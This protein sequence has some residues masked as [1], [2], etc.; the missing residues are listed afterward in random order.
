MNRKPWQRMALSLFGIL[1]IVFMWRWTVCHLY[2]L[3]E[4][5]LAPFST[6]TTNA[7]YTISAIVIFMISGR[8]VYD[9]SNRTQAVVDVVSNV[10]HIKE[11][12]VSKYEQQYKDEPSYPKF[13]PGYDN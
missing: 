5:A 6:L 10:A 8:L 2:T 7:M 3:P 11:D 13:D 1:I 4:I 9:W 12:L